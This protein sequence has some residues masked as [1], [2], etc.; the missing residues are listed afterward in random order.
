M[1]QQELQAK[2]LDLANA[3]WHGC[4]KGN[5]LYETFLMFKRV[6]PLLTQSGNE[7]FITAEIIICKTCGKIPPFFANKMSD[8]PPE[9]VPECKK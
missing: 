9:L 3:P 7:E 4:E 5:L 6:S 2:G 1:N 8:C